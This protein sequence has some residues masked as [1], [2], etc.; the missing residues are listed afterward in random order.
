M[1]I[2]MIGR[3][4]IPAVLAILSILIVSKEFET[5]PIAVEKQDGRRN[6]ERNDVAIVM[7][8]SNRI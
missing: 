6:G 4:R 3:K 1:Y 8:V 5:H 2:F 7:I